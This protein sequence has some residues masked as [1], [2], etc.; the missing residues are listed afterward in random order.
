MVIPII[1]VGIVA[2][3]LIFAGI[4]K[5]ETPLLEL[6]FVAF[7]LFLLA[8]FFFMLGGALTTYHYIPQQYQVEL[9]NETVITVSTNKTIHYYAYELV[10]A[11]NVTAQSYYSATYL[12][13]LGPIMYYIGW[14]VLVID[15]IYVLVEIIV[16][17]LVAKPL[18]ELGEQVWKK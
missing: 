12:Q 8:V 5:R 6:F 14:A 13:S 17:Q 11:P 10:T 7:G 18:T 4:L 9:A 16:V 3:A 2:L 1:S 15:I